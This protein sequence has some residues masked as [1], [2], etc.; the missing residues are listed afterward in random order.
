MVIDN[1]Q[2]RRYEESDLDSLEHLFRTHFQ[3]DQIDKRKLIFDWIARHNPVSENGTNYLVI[4]DNGRIIAYEGRMP[5]D[6]MVNGEKEKGSY[7]LYRFGGGTPGLPRRKCLL[8]HQ[9]CS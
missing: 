6:L 1:F 7:Y 2:L 5:I 3:A 4:D 9:T 8:C